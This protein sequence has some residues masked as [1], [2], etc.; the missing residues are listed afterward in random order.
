MKI[1]CKM[2]ILIRRSDM[3]GIILY[4]FRVR[5]LH[6]SSPL[7]LEKKIFSLKILKKASFWG[8]VSKQNVLFYKMCPCPQYIINLQ[9]YIYIY[10]FVNKVLFIIIL[11]RKLMGKSFRF[12]SPRCHIMPKWAHVPLKTVEWPLHLWEIWRVIVYPQPHIHNSVG[13]AWSRVGA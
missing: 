6:P 2:P 7:N 9:K 10:I 12:F 8:G 3:S 1:L 11:L 5:V 4:L 13:W